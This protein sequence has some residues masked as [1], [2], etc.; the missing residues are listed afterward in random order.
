M[1]EIAATSNPLATIIAL[2][3]VVAEPHRRLR[4]VRFWSSVKRLRVSARVG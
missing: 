2:P 1:A 4:D 3:F